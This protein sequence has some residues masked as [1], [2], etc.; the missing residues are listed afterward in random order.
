[1][2]KV[3]FLKRRSSGVLII[4]AL[5]IATVNAQTPPPAPTTLGSQE[6]QTTPVPPS[7]NDQG[8]SPKAVG[9]Q[10]PPS[11][12]MQFSSS[13]FI[14]PTGLTL[15]NLLLDGF[16]RRADI[17]AARQRL[18]I[19]EG[20]LIQAGLRPNPTV[21]S[22]YASAKFLG[23]QNEGDMTFGISQ[24]FE[25][26]GKR[27]KRVT[28]ARLEL[29]QV[30]AEVLA[31]E[32]QFAA[33]L[34]AAYARALAA[35]RQLDTF[36]QLIAASNELVRITNERLE[37]GDVAPLELNI[38]KVE[39][40]R[41]RT[42]AINARAALESENISLHTLVALD[43][44]EPL[45]I[46]PLPERPPR[47]DLSL[48]EATG[49]AMRERADLQAARL[50]EQAGSARIN[51][52]RAQGVPDFALNSK[53]SVRRDIF[54]D[55]PVGPISDRDKLLSFGVSVGLPVFNRNQGEIAAATAERVQAQRQREFLETTI[56]RDVALAYRRYR[57]AA[58][59]LVI[60]AT[61]I[62]PNAEKNLQTV[63]AAYNA[64]EFSIFDVL[65]EQRR[66]IENETGYNE[67]LGD[68]Y[69][70][71]AELERALGTTIPPSAFAPTTVT[72][73][74]DTDWTTKAKI[75][76]SIKRAVSLPPASSTSLGGATP[77][78]SLVSATFEK[79]QAPKS[80]PSETSE[81][82]QPK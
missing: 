33:D 61:Q 54:D 40:D 62:I 73:L 39:T 8:A 69:G 45:R 64:G 4:G 21:D 47:L 11:Q 2:N 25:T 80:S 51:L 15:D 19:A 52:A 49:L 30:K 35:G 57:A 63:R 46:A 41:L 6:Q 34:R 66:L 58:E 81:P 38:V 56:Q 67:A 16:T 65:S 3:K 18:A 24:V 9:G 71:L 14:D 60:Y 48:D 23:G 76:R 68:Y 20:R 79:A 36:E 53:V 78:S 26:G 13:Q 75:L 31:L 7:S 1:M 44:K 17:L 70:A 43:Q 50:G 22:D 32:R 77:Q 10:L 5:V 12:P 74:P 82:K 37:Q 55:T 59:T 27:S 42:Q 72:I 28:V 29:A